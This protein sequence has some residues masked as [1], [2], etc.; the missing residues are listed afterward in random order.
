M[1]IEAQASNRMRQQAQTSI[2]PDQP[3]RRHQAMSIDHR[4]TCAADDAIC[5]Y[6]PR[7]ISCE[8]VYR[9]SLETK[10]TEPPRA[11]RCEA[12]DMSALSMCIERGHVTNRKSSERPEDAAPDQHGRRHQAMATDH[13]TAC[14]VEDAFCRFVLWA[15]SCQQFTEFS[16]AAMTTESHRACRCEAGGTGVLLRGGNDVH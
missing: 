12:E 5:R 1:C 11:C 4:T 16:P 7:A 15:I 13:R 6:A 3:E 10:A 2:A 14:A 9:I 8:K